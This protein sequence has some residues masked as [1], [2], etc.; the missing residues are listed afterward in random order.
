M[1]ER[2][3]RP[4]LKPGEPKLSKSAHLP[5]QVH[6]KWMKPYPRIMEEAEERR[7]YR[8]QQ[9]AEARA[10]AT[11]YVPKPPCAECAA[12]GGKHAVEGGW[13]VD[14]V[15]WSHVATNGAKHI[16]ILAPKGG[17]TMIKAINTMAKAFDFDLEQLVIHTNAKD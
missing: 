1:Q 7:A 5:R 4:P 10:R 15:F 8:E 9:L 16:K 13:C 12:N 2:G 6:P 14:G 3:I 17:A 11:P